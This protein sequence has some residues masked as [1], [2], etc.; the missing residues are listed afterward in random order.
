LLVFFNDFFFGEQF[1]VS[2]TLLHVSSMKIHGNSFIA[3]IKKL[4][5]TPTLFFWHD[6]TKL[7]HFK[8]NL[9][10][11]YIKLVFFFKKVP[12]LLKMWMKSPNS[13]EKVHEY[14]KEYNWKNIFWVQ[15][16][17]E[18]RNIVLYQILNDHA[19]PALSQK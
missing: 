12:F 11:C 16:M 14:N 13:N 17:G 8:I 2:S 6:G 10:F 18:Y 4:L 15:K 7:H 9:Y 5:P 1:Y 19:I 3:S